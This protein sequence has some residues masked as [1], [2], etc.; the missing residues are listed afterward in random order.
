MKAEKIRVFLSDPQILFREGI[1]FT[2]SGEDDFNV[3]GEATSN[4]DALAQI[5]ADPP[6][7]AVLSMGNGSISGPETTRRIKRNIPSVSVILIADKDDE[8]QQLFSA[9]KSGASACLSKDIN[10]EYMVNVM[11]EVARGGKPVTQALLIPGVA[12]KGLAEFDVLSTFGE[13]FDSLLARLSPR[14]REVLKLIEDGNGIEQVAAR[15]AGSEQDVKH[16]LGLIADKLVAND[17][18]R[19]MIEA[20]QQAWPSIISGMVTS[21][22]SA[23]Y[24]TREEFNEFKE[25]LMQRF[26]SFTGDLSW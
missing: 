16:Q 23:G 25:I 4:E 9:L 24:I 3:T 1:H 11:R 8:E 21:S 26:K 14:E 6:A 18:A 19:A 10:P 17:Q 15:L 12:S 7:I 5:E 13:K 2:L 20:A 22:P